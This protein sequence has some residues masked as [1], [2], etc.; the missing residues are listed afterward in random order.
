MRCLC[1]C[2]SWIASILLH[3]TTCLEDLS[4]GGPSQVTSTRKAAIPSDFGTHRRWNMYIQRGY[5]KCEAEN[6]AYVH[7]RREHHATFQLATRQPFVSLSHRDCVTRYVLSTA[8]PATMFD[9]YQPIHPS[10]SP[11]PTNTSRCIQG[12]DVL[13]LQ[14]TAEVLLKAESLL[15]AAELFVQLGHPQTSTLMACGEQSRA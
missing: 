4:Y 15:L 7:S 1:P 6:P 13:T 14:V 12:T 11:P 9:K 2:F 3:C 10:D 8:D 5:H